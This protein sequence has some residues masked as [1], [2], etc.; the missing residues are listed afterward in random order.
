MNN[1]GEQNTKSTDKAKPAE[2]KQSIKALKPETKQ[3]LC[4]VHNTS[5]ETL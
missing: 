3:E 4:Y 5:P 1:N 2:E